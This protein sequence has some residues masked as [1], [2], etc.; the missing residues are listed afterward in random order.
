MNVSITAPLFDPD[1]HLRI[2]ALPDSE[3]D[4]LTRRVNRVATLDGGATAN[5]AGHS[6]ADRDFRLRWRPS[7]DELRQ[8]QRMVRLYPRLTVCNKEGVFSAIP[9]EIT[10]RDGIADLSLLVMEQ[11]T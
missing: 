2:N 8:A 4:T 11:Y 1:G 9:S 7:L 6:P 5:D 3:M 10:M